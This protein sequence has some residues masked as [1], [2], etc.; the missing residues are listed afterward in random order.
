MLIVIAAVIIIGLLIWFYE[1]ERTELR[2][3]LEATEEAV[4]DLVKRNRALR[5]MAVDQQRIIAHPFTSNDFDE[6]ARQAIAV[7]QAEANILQF[8]DLAETKPDA[9]QLPLFSRE[10]ID[11]F[12]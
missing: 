12:N 2:L 3:M 6:H 5:H 9:D 10:E 7:A 8:P 1:N 11:Q 4:D